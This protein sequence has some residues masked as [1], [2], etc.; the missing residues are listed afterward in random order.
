[1]SGAGLVSSKEYLGVAG[2]ILVTEALHA[3][4]RRFSLGAVAA[5]IPYG[6]GLGLNEVY[7]LAAAFFASC[8]SENP[9][10]AGV[11]YAFTAEMALA[12]SLPDVR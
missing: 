3:P 10:A 2:S 5:A 4:L 8:P 12:G 1:M 6:T 11:E 7:T 9:A